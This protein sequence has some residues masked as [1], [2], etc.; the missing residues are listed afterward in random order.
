MAIRRRLELEQLGERLLPSATPLLLPSFTV[1]QALAAA[2]PQQHHALAGHGEGTFTGHSLIVDAGVS[3]DLQGTADLARLGAVTVSGSVHGLGNILSGHA[4][5]TLTFTND[6]G[7]VTVSLLGPLQK[8]FA[9]LP[10]DWHY[11]VTDATG[12]FK[13]L[14]DQGTLHLTFTQDPPGMTG[15]A[16]FPPLAH[17]TFTLTSPGAHSGHSPKAESGID[18]VAM[19]G[20]IFP[21]DRPGVPNTRPLAG[22]VIS[23]EPANGGPELTRVVADKNGRFH[24]D[25]AP[26]TYRLIP[27]P[28]Q[29]GEALPRGTPL[30]VVVKPG[31]DTD[32]TVN[33]DSGIR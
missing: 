16:I 33:Y 14:K 7:S 23:V 28:P 12:A 32:V 30:T 24:I 20:P 19:V 11:Q 18:G 6:Q 1:P 10:T 8:F 26:G 29:P 25:L 31:D 21:V 3:Y 22:A 4:T 15:I 27:L 5:G 2:H 13:G 17:G 9:P